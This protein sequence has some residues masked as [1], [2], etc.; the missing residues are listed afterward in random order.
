MS[1]RSTTTDLVLAFSVAFVITLAFW[2]RTSELQVVAVRGDKD[3]WNE[4]SI[5]LDDP[6]LEE[7]QSKLRQW[8][9]YQS[10]EDY[11]AAKWQLELAEFYAQSV[12][13]SN[14]EPVVALAHIDDDSNNTQSDDSSPATP[15]ALAT[16][17]ESGEPT[18]PL[19]G[20]ATATLSDTVATVAYAEPID[21][22]IESLSSDDTQGEG[23]GCP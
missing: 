6:R 22:A 3:T 15:Q 20:A 1:N 16:V 5:A 13:A 12:D 14:E 10:R 8:G 2:A 17:R 11:V 23:L 7:L 18:E 4:Y 21:E 9:D 19:Q